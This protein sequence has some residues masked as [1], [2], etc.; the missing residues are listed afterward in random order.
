[1]NFYSTKVWLELTIPLQW[2]HIAAKSLGNPQDPPVLC[3]P[4]WTHNLGIFEKLL[5]LLPEKKYFVFID[6]LGRGFSSHLPE[7]CDYTRSLHV[8]SFEKI[9]RYFNWD[10]FSLLGH[11]YGG[12]LAA[13]YSSI[14]PE[15]VDKLILLDPFN[16]KQRKL[17]VQSVQMKAIRRGIEKSITIGPVNNAALSG[18]T[19][20]TARSIFLKA[21]P[22]LSVD[23][24]DIILQRAIKKDEKDG[25][26][27]Y[28]HDHRL[29]LGATNALH[30][31]IE[32]KLF[33]NIKAQTLHIVYSKEDFE[34]I[35]FENFGNCKHRENVIVNGNHLAHLCD[36]HAV[37]PHIISFLQRPPSLSIKPRL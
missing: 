12:I 11:C 10:V 3:I 36:P 34:G 14:F 30:E 27:S 22:Y 20:E 15:R 28:T 31:D 17:L 29:V 4:G 19:Y 24:A 26:Y 6:L 32:A 25:S 23:H 37:A 9:R 5:P 7:V 1:M 18:M 33:S 21:H 13:C 2:G 16:P 35:I 8:A